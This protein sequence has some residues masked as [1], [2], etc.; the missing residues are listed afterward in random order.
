MPSKM[1]AGAAARPSTTEAVSAVALLPPPRADP[2]PTRGGS[3][4]ESAGNPPPKEQRRK[5]KATPGSMGERLYLK[6]MQEWWTRWR[7]GAAP[8]AQNPPPGGVRQTGFQ[9]STR[10]FGVVNHEVQR[11]VYRHEGRGP[12]GAVF[13][14]SLC[15]KIQQNTTQLNLLHATESK[16]FMM[17]QIEKFT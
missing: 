10:T 17:A 11:L 5:V 15:Y 13:H 12:V 3:S 9:K 7:A 8:E 1:A 4:R 16:K 14:G 6:P 2:G